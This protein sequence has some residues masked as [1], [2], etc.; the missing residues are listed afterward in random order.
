[1]NAARWLDL[2]AALCR[3]I[4]LLLENKNA[5]RRNGGQ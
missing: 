4:F 2:L 5:R 3:L 1:M